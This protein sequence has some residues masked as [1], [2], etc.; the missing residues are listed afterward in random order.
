MRSRILER[1]EVIE[2][3]LLSEGVIGESILTMARMEADFHCEGTTDVDNGRFIKV[4]RGAATY[5]APTRRNHAG[6]PS[7]PVAV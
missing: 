4:A 7:K 3:G 2:I 5:G 1:T 6:M